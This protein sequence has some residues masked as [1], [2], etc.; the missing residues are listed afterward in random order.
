MKLSH[1][2]KTHIKDNYGDWAVVTGASSGIGLA[3]ARDLA[4]AGLNLIINSRKQNELQ[5]LADDIA[6]QFGVDV[7]PVAADLSAPEGIDRIIKSTAGKEIG[8]FVAS[9]G[10]GTSGLFIQ[11]SVHEEINM[12]RVNA[13]AVLSLTHY[14]SQLFSKQQGGG[15]ILLSSIVA[16]QGVPYAANYAASK[17]YVQSLAEALARE[18]KPFKVDVLA[19]APAPVKSGFGK[20]ANMKMGKA[21]DPEDISAPILKALGRQSNVLPGF[22]SKFLTYSLRTLPRRGKIRVMKMIMGGFTKHQRLA[23]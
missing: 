18:L 2:D 16:F 11:N 6:G 9:A 3:L 20:R 10:F 13:E 7:L 21:L 4:E 14:F 19:A 5:A 17:A 22:L 15:I 12:L 1:K 8:L 23:G